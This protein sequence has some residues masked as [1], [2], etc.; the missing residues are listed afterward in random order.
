MRPIYERTKNRIAQRKV[1]R[2]IER[3]WAVDSYELP[4]LA[5]IDFVLCHCDEVV[6]L[7][8]VKCRDNPRAQY[9]SF[10]IG[11]AKIDRLVQCA[12]ICRVAPILAVQWTDQLGWINPAELQPTHYGPGGRTDRGDDADMEECAFFSPAAFTQWQLRW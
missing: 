10:M 11:R 9:K 3:K 12:E 7:L 6:A 4:L 8:E 1:A 2:K 5:G